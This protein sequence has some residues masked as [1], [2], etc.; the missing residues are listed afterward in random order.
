[1]TDNTAANN[2]HDHYNWADAEKDMATHK[3]TPIMLSIPV[4][5]LTLGLYVHSR[6]ILSRAWDNKQTPDEIPNFATHMNTVLLFEEALGERICNNY[7]ELIKKERDQADTDVAKRVERFGPAE[8]ISLAEQ[9]IPS[10]KVVDR[11]NVDSSG[12][13]DDDEPPHDS[14]VP[15]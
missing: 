13:D 7:H 11:I 9:R 14:P 1:M 8:P 4:D 6:T 2:P 5:R 3:D 10:D 15:A 12:D